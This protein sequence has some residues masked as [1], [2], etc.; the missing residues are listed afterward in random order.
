LRAKQITE[1]YGLAAI[2][3]DDDAVIVDAADANTLI[4]CTSPWF[5]HP[6]IF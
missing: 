6:F 2:D 4:S 1:I 3:D 5:P